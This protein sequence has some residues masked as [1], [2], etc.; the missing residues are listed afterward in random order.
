MKKTLSIIIILFTV[1]IN[2]GFAQK[3]VNLEGI[4]IGNTAPEIKLPNVNGDIVTLSQ[5]KDKI[6]LLSFGASWCAP[7]RKKSPELLEVFNE[8]KDAEFEDGESGF[9]IVAVSL[10]NNEIAWRNS[11]ERDGTGEL[12]NIGDM[13][14][15]KC[16]AAVSYHIKSIP[17]TVLINGD[18]K[19]IAVNLNSRDLKRKLKQMKKGGW[20]WF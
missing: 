5:M 3:K 15:W 6:I 4:Q 16:D 14:G 17:S 1:L 7:C 19:I 8:F 18:G 2:T 11:I 10:D 13:K 12:I 20:L 9:A